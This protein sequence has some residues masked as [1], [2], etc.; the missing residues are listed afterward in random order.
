MMCFLAG[1]AQDVIVKRDGTTILAKVLKVSPSFVEYKKASNQDGPT[2]AIS[3]NDIMAINY[4]N[5]E[6]ESYNT[7]T[8]DEN[9]SNN[10]ISTTQSSVDNS[11]ST[12]KST[13]DRPLNFNGLGAYQ[14]KEDL[15]RSARTNK[16]WGTVC[17]VA[18]VSTAVVGLLLSEGIF[19]V[20]DQTTSYV[21]IGGGIGL[22]CIAGGILHG[23]AARQRSEAN[24][25]RVASLYKREY[26]IDKNTSVS[27]GVILM[28]NNESL[29]KN[30][31]SIGIGASLVF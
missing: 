30:K 15:L 16:T 13:Y 21:L 10:T 7:D 5:G 4:E 28:A 29:L 27:P 17:I 24:S 2:Y 11:L 6:K 23:I 25:I 9:T 12:S 22:G 14:E 20:M 3:V 26:K 1:S 19:D 31:Y 18:G 8:K